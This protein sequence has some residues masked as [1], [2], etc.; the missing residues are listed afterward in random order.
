MRHA[1]RVQ[2][3]EAAQLLHASAAIAARDGQAQVVVRAVNDIR[4]YTAKLDK[5]V[6]PDDGGAKGDK[7]WLAQQADE[8]VALRQSSR[9]MPPVESGGPPMPIEP[10]RAAIDERQIV[11]LV[12]LDQRALRSQLVR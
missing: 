2:A 8:D 12:L 9:P 4:R 3:I 6:T 7:R 5:N 11:G 10:R 1:A